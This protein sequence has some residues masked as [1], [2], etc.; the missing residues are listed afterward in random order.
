MSARQLESSLELHVPQYNAAT[1]AVDNYKPTVN[2]QLRTL[3]T[4]YFLK[5]FNLFTWYA[6]YYESS[7][8]VCGKLQFGRDMILY[9]IACM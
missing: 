9:S 8:H 7:N 1:L 4:K 3:K 2:Y 6:Y 5:I